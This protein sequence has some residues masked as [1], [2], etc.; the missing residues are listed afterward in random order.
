MEITIYGTSD[1][2]IEIEGD[3]REEF[4]VYEPVILAWP[5]GSRIRATYGLD[6]GVWRFAL[7][8][9]AFGDSYSIVQCD[10]NDGDAGY[11]DKVTFASPEHG[12]PSIHFIGASA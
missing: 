4:N 12:L 8:N 11:T 9:L 2:L 1:D 7:V 3:L 5:N 6:A 10:E